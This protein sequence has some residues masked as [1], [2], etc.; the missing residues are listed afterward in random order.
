MKIKKLTSHS[1]INEVLMNS[2]SHFVQSIKETQES[3][4]IFDS[5]ELLYYKCRKVNVVV[6]ILILE[7]R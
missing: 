6:H 1:E 5:I 2:L 7:T 3:D 4:F